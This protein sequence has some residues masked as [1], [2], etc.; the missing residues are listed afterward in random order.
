MHYL[1]PQDEFISCAIV[2]KSGSGKSYLVTRLLLDSYGGKKLLQ[3]D[4]LYVIAPVATFKRG[5][6]IKLK[7]ECDERG[8]KYVFYEVSTIDGKPIPSPEDLIEIQGRTVVIF[9]DL[10]LEYDRRS[11]YNVGQFFTAGRERFDCF[12]LAQRY[13]TVPI[14]TVRENINMLIVFKQQYYALQGI[15]KYM[16]EDIGWKRFLRFINDGTRERFHFVTIIDDSTHE[17]LTGKYRYGLDE[18][19]TFEDKI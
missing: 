4:M 7:E 9:D 8:I 11:K 15:Y 3:Y 6:Y 2:G 14:D 16:G 17:R 18:I 5:A 1:M 13:T 19:E 10:S 12:Y